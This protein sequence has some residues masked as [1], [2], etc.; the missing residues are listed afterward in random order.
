MINWSFSYFL[1]IPDK[2]SKSLD[3]CRTQAPTF[4]V[5]HDILDSLGRY[6]PPQ[7]LDGGLAVMGRLVAEPEMGTP[8]FGQPWRLARRWMLASD[9]VGQWLIVEVLV[10]A[11]VPG[12]AVAPAPQG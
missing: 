10:D 12:R 1:S 3:W 11:S 9:Q 8:S 5:D 2:A 4:T 6:L 7:A